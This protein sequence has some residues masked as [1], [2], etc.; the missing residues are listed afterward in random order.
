MSFYRESFVY[1]C[2][3]RDD[4]HRIQ[5]RCFIYRSI[6]AIPALRKRRVHVHCAAYHFRMICLWLENPTMIIF[7]HTVLHIYCHYFIYTISY[8]TVLL[9]L[10][11]HRSHIWI[12]PNKDPAF[13]YRCTNSSHIEFEHRG[14][15]LQNI[16][17][18]RSTN[19]YLQP[20]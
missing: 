16:L 14:A 9:I 12:E 3:R 11:L 18:L 4:A 10:F 19:F 7:N 6:F 2:T 17:N 5:Q 20:L 1:I 13:F 15:F 8:S